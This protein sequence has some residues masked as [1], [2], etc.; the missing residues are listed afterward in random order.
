MPLD[1]GVGRGQGDFVLYGEPPSLLPKKGGTAPQF[2]TH[3][4][5]DQTAGW[6]KM[7]LSTLS[8]T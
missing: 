2:L 1:T 6:I 4:Y 8:V 5:C 3:V 7:L